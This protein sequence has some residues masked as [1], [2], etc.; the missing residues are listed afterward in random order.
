MAGARLFFI[1]ANLD[2]EELSLVDNPKPG[3]GLRRGDGTRE[4][5]T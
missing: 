5:G 3:T 4:V 2:N 1:H